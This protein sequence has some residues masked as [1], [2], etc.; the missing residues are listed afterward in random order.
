MGSKRLTYFFGPH[1]VAHLKIF[2]ISLVALETFFSV[3][4]SLMRVLL[5]SN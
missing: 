2:H 1:A 3:S 5:S 4:Q